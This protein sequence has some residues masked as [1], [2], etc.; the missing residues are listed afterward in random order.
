MD[1][2]GNI[3]K[4]GKRPTRRTNLSEFEEVIFSIIDAHDLI[5]VKGIAIRCPGTI[6]V[7]TGMIY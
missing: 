6:D 1:S 7:D 2:A 3:I 4:K 5:N